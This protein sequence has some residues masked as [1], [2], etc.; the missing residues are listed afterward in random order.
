MIIRC[1]CATAACCLGLSGTAAA[2][3]SSG[4][5]TP[6]TQAPAAQKPT[7]PLLSDATV[8]PDDPTVTSPVEAKD[9]FWK[10]LLASINSKEEGWSPSVGSVVSGGGL[11]MGAHNRQSLASGNV[12]M[13]T[14]MMVSLKGYQ[15]GTLDFTSRPLGRGGRWSVGGGLRFESL[16]QE[17]FFGFGPESSSTDHA[18]Y[19]RQGL[20]TQVWASFAPTTWLQLRSSFGFVNTKVSDGQQSGIPSIE[21]TF[22][23]SRVEGMSR[24]SDFLHAGLRAT[25]D[26]RDSPR[27]T[28][29]GAYY[30][31]GVERFVGL[32]SRDS[33]FLRFDADIRGYVPVRGLGR[34]DSIA[35]RGQ[36][37][38]TDAANRGQIPF[39]FLP[40]LGGGGTLRGYETSRFIDQQALVFSAEYRWQVR[41]KLQIVG[42]VDAGQ[43][44]STRNEFSFSKLQSS[45][46][47]GI[48]FKGFRL[49]Y[50]VGQEGSRVHIGFGPTF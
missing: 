5:A 10:S 11:A 15:S 16:P 7:S 3:T 34:E 42:F 18:S 41:R 25:I 14:D 40:R 9:G 19:H 32:G 4:S 48:R 38:V 30:A 46:G 12:F 6:P 23:A 43:V 29:R 47:A 17:D 36:L 21:E 35:V 33:D 49:D 27:R 2:Q 22:S 13:D 50:A 24:E 39:Y 31:F 45:Y 28:R 20:D 1:L 44:A 26:R 8:R 37:A